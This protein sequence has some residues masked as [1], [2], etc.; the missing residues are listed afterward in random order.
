MPPSTRWELDAPA[1]FSPRRAEEKRSLGGTET[2]PILAAGALSLLCL[3]KTSFEIKLL[4]IS[5]LWVPVLLPP[6]ARGVTFEKSSRHLDK[7]S[8]FPVCEMGL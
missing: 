2:Q 5:Q 1:H 3:W 8:V 6:P 7:A 4:E